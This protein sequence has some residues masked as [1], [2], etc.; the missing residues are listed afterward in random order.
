MG[1]KKISKHISLGRIIVIVYAVAVIVGAWPT[2]TPR[3]YKG[4]EVGIVGRWATVVFGIIMFWCGVLYKFSK[5]G[6]NFTRHEQSICSKCQK[7]YL[8]GQAPAN[9][10]CELC[11]I[12]LE[13]LDGF[14]ER[15]PELK[16]APE[17]FTPP[18]ED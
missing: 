3:Y 8:A 5:G 7:V 4:H 15:H 2:E 16:D 9:A 6:K 1:I 18:E 13:P 17:E 10:S 14:Y 11:G 12:N